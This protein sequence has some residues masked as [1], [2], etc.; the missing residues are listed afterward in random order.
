M[1][2]EEHD[3]KFEGL[4]IY[5]LTA[6]TGPPLMLLHGAGDNALG[7]WWAM[8]TLSATHRVYASNLLSSPD[9]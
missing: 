5:Y 3:T 2:V 4:P 8:P 6:G 9:S 1:V 7:W